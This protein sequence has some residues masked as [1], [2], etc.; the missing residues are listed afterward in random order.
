[1]R[2][3]ALLLVTLALLTFAGN[4][5][6]QGTAFTYQGRLDNGT[7]AA[8]GSYDLRF[9]LF[10]TLPGGTGTQQGAL[11]TNSAIF[12]TN[13][14]FTVTL[15]F[16]NQFS[17][18]AR[19]LEI[20]VRSNGVAT[21]NLLSPR[22]PLTPAPYA[23]FAGTAS[24][25][26]GFVSASQI[27]GQLPSAVLAGNYPNPVN[28]SSAGNS[29]TG[30]GG[31]LTGV[32][33]L[34]AGN[35]FTSDQ[36]VL[37][38]ITAGGS[39][40]AVTLLDRF[41]PVNGFGWQWR[42][43]NTG[44]NAARFNGGG[45][46]EYFTISTNGLVGI[47]TITP[48]TAL[49]V[50][51]TV[52]ATSF[53]GDGSGLTG[54]SATN[55]TNG[56][57]A[58]ALLSTNV[59]LRSGGNTFGGTQSFAGNVGIG[60]PTPATTLAISNSVG[61]QLELD[62]ASVVGVRFHNPASLYDWDI[63]NDNIGWSLSRHNVDYPFSIL[64]NGAVAIGTGRIVTA[65]NLLEVGGN[66]KVDGTVTAN[67][68][69]VNGTFTATALQVNGTAT[70]TGFAGSGTAVEFKVNGQRG[71]RLEYG[72]DQF[73]EQTSGNVIGGYASN[74]VASGVV[75]ATIAGGG[76][77]INDGLV[78][79]P[80]QV[81]AGFGTIGGG[82]LNTVG[83]NGTFATVGG[84]FGNT[85][86]QLGATVGGGS[87]NTATGYQATIPGGQNNSAAGENSFAAGSGAQA[88]HDG[89]FVWADDSVGDGFASTAANQF[90]IR[91]A[92]G[93]GIG[94][95]NPSAPLC[96]V[97]NPTGSTLT[98]E[99]V[100]VGI[101]TGANVYGAAIVGL[102]LVPGGNGIIGEADT[103]GSGGPPIGV[104]A[105]SSATGGIGLE[106]SASGANSFAAQFNGV[107]TFSG[108]VGIGTT[109]PTHA[110]LEV[111]GS[112]GSTS[113]SGGRY[114]DSGSSG[115]SVLGANT[116][117]AAIYANGFVISTGGFLAVSDQRV[118]NI[119]GQS[120][121][122]CD[123]ETLRHIQVTDYTYK[124]TIAK[125]NRPQKKVIAQQVEQFYPQAISCSTNEVPD[126][127]QHATIQDGW[128]QLATDLKAGERVKLLGE[129]EQGIYPVLEVRD[130]A[131]RTDFK[132]KTENIFVYGREVGDFRTVDYDAIAML[133]VSAT[134]ELARKVD[135]QESEL[136]ALRT[137][138]TRLRGEKETLANT[139]T[140]LKECDSARED[141]LARI[142]SSLEKISI[143]S[144][145]ASLKQ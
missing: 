80:N 34:G 5:R 2:K 41:H 63:V 134:Q 70:A 20:A 94:T 125:G 88:N 13:G 74:S 140:E 143:H 36:T 102:S 92:G 109:T 35:T 64:T 12:V 91:A 23:V 111:G 43:D 55:V 77:Y 112:S 58:D 106:A 50:I 17:G 52:T 67:A 22:Q 49:Q 28:F 104:I 31:G 7:N 122:A 69:Q 113:Y 1:M 136:T 38:Q 130:G 42:A 30:N 15:D 98:T 84:G 56:K 87:G 114:F 66:A 116:G 16:S 127:Y 101:Q 107:C 103:A 105:N 97:G 18:A 61:N 8:S 10:D 45:G 71:L 6:A 145:Y 135:A 40:G 47:G 133:N 81:Q 144:T 62:G 90:L 95:N 115:I 100:I 48:S 73:G 21:F 59:A 29:F 142:E 46:S 121:S 37:G 128:V 78:S 39:G 51:G 96:V 3:C 124:D 57:V 76:A 129:K 72:S 60:T 4:V 138:L 19:W 24:N 44:L 126:I 131:F 86:N 25:V 123:L 118:K 79:Q 9:A 108:K 75:G 27:F 65:G 53:S 139:V 110:F 120:D 117:P 99:G 33:L 132:P 137:E 83:A 14:L 82:R 68:L 26:N 93:V 141:R 85:V 54:L 119:L 32:A 11:L 89:A